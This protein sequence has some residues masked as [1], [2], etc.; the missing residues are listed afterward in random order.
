[1]KEEQNQGP[2]S[3]KVIAV[4]FALPEESKDFVAKLG[5]VRIMRRGSLPV[6]S[7]EITVG[8][9]VEVL[10]AALACRVRGIQ[11]HGKKSDKGFAGQRV[12]VNL[13]GV[14][15]TELVLLS[16]AELMSALDRG[17]FAAMGAA[18]GILLAVR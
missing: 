13:Q 10:P 15:H 6:I 2:A 18:A 14:E 8:D 11:T 16:K 1:M 17:E 12:A 9:E 5:N 3:K 4:T 7:G